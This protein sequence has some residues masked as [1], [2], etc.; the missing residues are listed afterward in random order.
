MVTKDMKAAQDK[1]FADQ[2]NAPDEAPVEMSEDAAFGITPD[3]TEP[4]ADS[5]TETIDPA[6]DQSA[7]EAA[8]GTG[9]VADPAM[10][11]AMPEGSP[12]EEAGESPAQEAAEP[13]PDATS[14]D[15]EMGN[16][17]MTEQQLRS[18]E[19]RL[20][21]QQADMDAGKDGDAEAKIEE[22]AAE[23]KSGDMTAEEAMATLSTD[24]GPEFVSMIQMIAKSSAGD[25]AKESMTGVQENVDNI[26]AHLKSGAEK[27]HFETIATAHPDFMEISTSPKFEAFLGTRPPEMHAQDKIT[28]ESGS[29]SAINDLLAAYK[30]SM[31]Q[32]DQSSD[33]T[34]DGDE[35]SDAAEGVRSGGI[36]LPATPSK[37]DS[38]EEAWAES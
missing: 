15:A 27:A 16:G 13:I 4:T 35:V 18:W 8:G 17:K 23:V 21:K 32:A 36:K 7:P 28:L 5:A 20:K 38:Y 14:G 33:D 1:E 25:V 6:A 22:V 2:F 3:A 12:A 11:T 26:I 9:E 19:G 10:D 37:S 29:A 34:G 24:F 31:S 30:T